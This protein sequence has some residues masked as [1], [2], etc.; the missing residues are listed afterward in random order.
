MQRGNYR[1][2]VVEPHDAVG[3]RLEWMDG[4]T[5]TVAWTWEAAVCFLFPKD[6]QCF[7]LFF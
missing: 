3:N 6:I 1:D 4:S 2:V 7:V 5:K